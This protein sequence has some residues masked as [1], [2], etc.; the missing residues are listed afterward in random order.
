MEPPHRPDE[1]DHLLDALSEEADRD[2]IVV[3]A[4]H[5]NEAFASE[6]ET[7]RPNGIRAATKIL[8]NWYEAEDVVDQE[9]A[10]LIINGIPYNAPHEPWFI[11]CVENGAKSRMRSA[12]WRNA[13][14]STVLANL[15]SEVEGPLE[16]ALQNQRVETINEAL[17][18]LSSDDREIL[19]LRFYEEMKIEDMA[20]YY[21]VPM[22]T[23][24]SQLKRAV[25]R[26]GRLLKKGGKS[27]V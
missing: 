23:L 21:N 18:G 3:L 27:N 14:D 8:R 26:L 10:K 16:Q 1:D 11:T 15:L 22:S 24:Y 12:S 13:Q 7:L 6:L 17:L 25:K 2:T 9:I 19:R 20:Q 5:D 4:P